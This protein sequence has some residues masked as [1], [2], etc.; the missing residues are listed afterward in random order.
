MDAVYVACEETDRWD[1]YATSGSQGRR[2]QSAPSGPTDVDCRGSWSDCDASCSTCRD[3]RKAFPGPVLSAG[4]NLAEIPEV[5]P[6]SCYLEFCA[7][8]EALPC[9]AKSSAAQLL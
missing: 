5:F 2:L 8:Q 1:P 3:I 6:F 7:R 9:F 4:V